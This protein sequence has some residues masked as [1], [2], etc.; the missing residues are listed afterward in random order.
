MSFYLA[1]CLRR[2]RNHSSLQFPLC[3]NQFIL[4]N[5]GEILE[6]RG[7]HGKSKSSGLQYKW[8]GLHWTAVHIRVVFSKWMSS[9][10][11]VDY[12]E[13][14]NLQRRKMISQAYQA[15][16]YRIYEEKNNTVNH[17]TEVTI[18]FSL[19]AK[20]IVKEDVSTCIY[21]MSMLAWEKVLCCW[22]VMKK[23]VSMFS[24]LKSKEIVLWS[25]L[26]ALKY[27]LVWQFPYSMRVKVSS[28][29]RLKRAGEWVHPLPSE[30]FS[31]LS[32]FATSI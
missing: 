23:G 1:V 7:K 18:S 20:K 14:W 19:L 24:W 29:S 27:A 12:W 17:A 6:R 15:V 22:K 11:C 8:I 28:L 13:T 4:Q 3:Y 30:F 16:F 26:G 31:F 21:N 5:R 25:H 10:L 32:A 2:I 9:F